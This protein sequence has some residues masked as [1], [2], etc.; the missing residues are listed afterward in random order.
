MEL[1]T[2]VDRAGEDETPHVLFS[3]ARDESLYQSEFEP[4][5]GNA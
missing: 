1:W 2:S 4:I 5:D 3:N